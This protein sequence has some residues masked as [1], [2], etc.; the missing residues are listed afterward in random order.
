MLDVYNNLLAK[1][2]ERVRVIIQDSNFNFA[3]TQ[4]WCGLVG[5]RT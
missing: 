4:A 2:I 1:D 5:S 3:S